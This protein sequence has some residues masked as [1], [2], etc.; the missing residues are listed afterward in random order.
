MNDLH[1]IWM[2]LALLVII[3]DVVVRLIVLPHRDDLWLKEELEML[4]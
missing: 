2:G 1:I 4:R 3:A